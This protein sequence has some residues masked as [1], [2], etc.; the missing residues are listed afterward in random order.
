MKTELFE[1]LKNIQKEIFKNKVDKD[2]NIS[3][4]EMEFCHI[5][6]ELA[7]AYNAYRKK[8][9]DLGEELADVAI[10]LYGISEILGFDLNEE[11][12]KK[13]RKNRERKYI[14]VDGIHVKVEWYFVF[15]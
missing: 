15:D 1:E 2:F 7:E 3:N 6:G 13:V 10:Y 4:V 11:I 5:Q 9:P 14:E 12:I 8:L